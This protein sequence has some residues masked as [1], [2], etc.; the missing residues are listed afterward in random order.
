MS[1]HSVAELLAWMDGKSKTYGWDALVTYDQ[2]KTNELLQQQY[3]ERFNETDSYMP[4]ITRRLPPVGVTT[5][6]LYGLKLGCPKLSFENADLSA[7]K[8]NLT[9]DMAGGLIVSELRPLGHPSRVDRIQQLL[10][11]GAPQ[12]TMTMPL[13]NTPGTVNAR[14]VTL[15]ISKGE[16]IRANFVIG[17]MDQKQ[18]GAFFGAMFHDLEDK[19]KIFVL[20]S[21]SGEFNDVLTPEEFQIRTVA[22][23]LADRRGEAN[24]GDGAV[25]M[26]ITFKGG[27]NGNIPPKPNPN[28]P[29]GFRYLIPKDEGKDTYTGSMLLS[30]RVFFDKVIGGGLAKSLGRGTEFKAYDGTSDRAWFLTAISGSIP[31]SEFNPSHV[32]DNAQYYNSLTIFWS[33]FKYDF[34]HDQLKVTANNR[35]LLIS[36][37]GANFASGKGVDLVKP[38]QLSTYDLGY[39]FPHNHVQPFDAVIDENSG[40]VSFIRKTISQFQLDAQVDKYFRYRDEHM[41]VLRGKVHSA[42]APHVENAFARIEIPSV[43][44]F[45]ARNL[46][47]PGTNALQLSS[48]Y[49]PG[50]LALFGHVDPVRT[51]MVITPAQS[52]LEAGTQLQFQVAGGG[53]GVPSLMWS[54][55]DADNETGDVGAIS[56]TGL[57]SAPPASSLDKG[58]VSVLVTAEGTLDG[59]PVRAMALV[60]IIDNTIAVNPLFQVGAPAQRIKL[61]AQTIDGSE[62]QWEGDTLTPDPD[63]AYHR[64]YTAPDS[65]GAFTVDTVKCKAAGGT[66]KTVTLLIVKYTP[67]L[68]IKVIDST[69]LDAGEVRLQVLAGDEVLDPEEWGFTLN[70]I[71]GGGH[72]DAATSVYKQPDSS[73]ISFAVIT[74][75]IGGEGREG[76]HGFIVLPLPLTDYELPSTFNANSLSKPGRSLN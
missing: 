59:K 51:S 2:R 62:P 32:I 75:S 40:L 53:A 4:L 43:D 34:G 76:F 42:V 58:Y 6:T 47:F 15:D 70:L 44:T 49:V 29:N 3:I 71:H 7:S 18:I 31:M 30:N 21:L 17:D 52:M 10:P 13:E 67:D 33:D 28:D 12:L 74:V 37:L 24:Y 60:S 8:A 66:P 5:E 54:V 38:D 20:G 36:W 56:P 14:K 73:L 19:Q 68:T 57:Y 1:N 65:A 35:G 27:V 25:M 9:V 16:N 72:L 26:F 48:V 41:R 46:L 69:D 39:T 64:I 11:L 55:R 63:N 61:T 23:P 45:L 50:D 22:A